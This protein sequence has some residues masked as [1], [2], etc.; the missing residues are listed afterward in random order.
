[1]E[2]NLSVKN[3]LYV[4]FALI[5]VIAAIIGVVGYTQLS[6]VEGE[7]EYLL[8]NLYV[9]K[10]CSDE[11]VVE[12][13]TAVEAA[14]EYVAY[15]FGDKNALS[16]YNAANDEFDN[17]E[18]LAEDTAEAIGDTDIINAAAAVDHQHEVMIAAAD[19]MIAAYDEISSQTDD[20]NEIMAYV[21]PYMEA[22]DAEWAQ[23]IDD[24]ET[25]E[26]TNEELIIAGDELAIKTAQSAYTMLIGIS[27]AA[28][29]AAI[30]LGVYIA[31]DIS[32]PLSQLVSDTGFVAQGD[33]GHQFVVKDR[34]DEIGEVIGA[35]KDM[36]K[37]TAGLVGNVT[38]ASSLVVSLSQELSSTAQQANASMEQVSSATQQIAQ[39]AAQLSAL[40]QES[41]QNANKLSAVL[42]QTGANSEKAGESIQQIMNAMETTTTT[43]E[44]MDKSLEEIGSL[45]N[46]VTDVA[47]QTQ[48]LALNAAI[49]A[50]RAGEA[51]RGFAVVADAVRELSEQTNQ[52]AADTLKSVG[53]VQKNGKDA[54]EVAQGSTTEAAAGVDVVN[55]TITGVNQGVEAVESVVKAI[56]E[57]ASI[58]EEAA[59]SAEENTAAA[60]EQ[61]AAMNELANNAS[62]LEEIANELE[63]ELSKFNITGMSTTQNCWE[64]LDCGREPGGVKSKELGVCPASVDTQSDGI[65]SGKNAGRYCWKVAGTFCGGKVQGNWADKMSNCQDC[66]VYKRVKNQEGGS[67]RP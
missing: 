32:N 10:D 67:F 35:V 40:S 61:T 11:M 13:R 47:N 5:A 23:I 48:L 44:N 66:M 50:A 51:G 1:M 39:G 34:N 46:I 20:M 55:E 54:I 62:N 60:E 41:S 16:G 49:E 18:L 27:V 22:F 43:V 56:D 29:A 28:V 38:N 58:A 36:V 17:L 15:S 37:N 59:S 8:R 25:L 31:R 14:T 12:V 30:V 57:M 45:A 26:W 53:D 42:Q 63:R 24:L 52:A 3:K 9:I 2:L 7:Y 19:D 65:N 64:I 4:G 21:G 33:L 6:S